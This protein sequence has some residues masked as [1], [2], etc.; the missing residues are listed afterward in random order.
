LHRPGNAVGGGPASLLVNDSGRARE[1]LGWT[2]KYPNL[3]QQIA[4]A[5]IWFHDKMSDA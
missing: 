3:D 5:W 4:H 1:L 2:P